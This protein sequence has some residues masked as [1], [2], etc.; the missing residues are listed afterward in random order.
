MSPL[1]TLNQ[2]PDTGNRLVEK[3]QVEEVQVDVPR[4]QAVEMPQCW[5]IVGIQP[6]E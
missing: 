1:R 3:Y 2:S 5:S 6:I 4:D